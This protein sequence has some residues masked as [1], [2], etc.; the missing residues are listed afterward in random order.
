MKNLLFLT[1]LI[2]LASCGRHAYCT[3]PVISIS[4][5]PDSSGVLVYEFN[6]YEKGTGFSKLISSNTDSVY[7]DTVY[8]GTT[9]YP[10]SHAKYTTIDGNHD[11][12][13]NIPETGKTYKISEISYTG[14]KK[15]KADGGFSELKTKCTRTVS[16][17]VNG[18]T[19]TTEG[20][21]HDGSQGPYPKAPYIGITK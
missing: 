17:K 13:I 12:I 19:F 14:D 4:Y 5:H 20:I 3:D 16:Y 8:Y 15:V 21:T 10:Q 18:Q 9:P 2:L 7:K 6:T 11:Y 1:C